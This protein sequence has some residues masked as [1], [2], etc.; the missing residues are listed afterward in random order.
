MTFLRLPEKKGTY[1]TAASVLSVRVGSDTMNEGGEV[2][3]VFIVI[4]H[5]SF[6]TYSLD[7]DFA[8][9]RLVKNIQ[10]DG[11]RKAPIALP[12]DDELVLD[13]SEVLVSGW[14]LTKKSTESNKMLRGVKI[15]TLNQATCNR[16]YEYDGGVTKQMLCAGSLGKDSC[17]VSEEQ[18]SFLSI[19]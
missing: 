2:I 13:G 4:N 10:F 1:K 19:N 16:M 3:D 9:L 18:L 5:S 6:K 12:R 17:N 14:G 8:L 15:P 7:F 11:V